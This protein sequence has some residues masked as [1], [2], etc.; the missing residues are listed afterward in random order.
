M[1]SATD[2]D[3][4]DYFSDKTLV[5]DPY[6]YYDYLRQKGPVTPIQHGVLAVTGYDEA[7]EVY[8]DTEHFSAVNSPTGPFPPLPFQPQGDD[9]TQQIKEHRHHF[10]LNEHMATFDPPEH[11]AHRALLMRLLTPNRIKENEEFMW[12]L[13]DRLLDEFASD[14]RCEFIG[15]YSQRF[16]LQVICDLLGVPDEDHE[17]FRQML[18][19]SLDTGQGASGRVT[20]NRSETVTMNPLQFLDDWFTR[21]VRDRRSSPQSDVLTHLATT[22]FP[23]GTLPPIEDVVHLATFLFIAGQETTAKLI[24]Q[25]VRVLAESPELQERLRGDREL[26]PNF[27]EETLRLHTPVKSAFR[28]AKRS[29]RIGDVPVPA[30]TTVMLAIAGANRDPRRFANPHEFQVERRNA[31]EHMAFTR[32][33]HVCPG[34]P[35]ARME[36]RASLERILERMRDIRLDEAQ[37]GPPGARRFDWVPTYV[38]HGFRSLHI[39]YGSA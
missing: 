10:P 31:R 14:G 26:I 33:A 28:L 19:T 5:A 24:A 3:R 18:I 20:Q 8:R 4:I 13:A 37:H 1:T 21:Y 36:A 7:V 39:E 25:A 30:G 11:T 16:T 29:T 17:L 2:F 32:G 15:Q 22:T 12:Q 6:P 38:L 34:A 9:I 23:D 27:I 35:L